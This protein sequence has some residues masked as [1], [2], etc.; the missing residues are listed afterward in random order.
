MVGA[1]GLLHRRGGRAVV[2]V[3]VG[4]AGGVGLQN[5]RAVGPPPRGFS[6]YVLRLAMFCVCT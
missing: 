4:V 5:S 6:S 3:P 1:A 2:A